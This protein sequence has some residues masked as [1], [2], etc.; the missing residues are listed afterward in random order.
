MDEHVD[1]WLTL[2]RSAV[3][4][5]LLEPIELVGTGWD[6][7]VLRACAQDGRRWIFRFPRRPELL[8]DIE[9]EQDLLALLV[10]RLPVDIPDW[11]IHRFVPTA[12]GRQFVVGY[13]E[14][15]GRPAAQE[16]DDSGEVTFALTLPPPS[17]YTDGLGAA[18]AALHAM[19]G[20]EFA[21][22]HGGPFAADL[23]ARTADL[24]E[25]VGT[26]PGDVPAILREYWRAWIQDDRL[27][28]FTTT[29]C[30]G[31]LHPEHTMIDENGALTGIIDWTDSEIGDPAVDF[32]GTRAVL[33]PEFGD[34]LLAAYRRAGGPI[35]TLAERIVRWQSIGPL[36]AARFGRKHGRV[37]LVERA[38]REIGDRADRLAAGRP[39][40]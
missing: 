3:P 5:L 28:D 37:E 21:K 6:S 20:R 8:P 35:G 24:L 14:L 29:L 19:D 12:S 11:Q 31:D 18:L 27:W 25:S 36:H 33:G 10:G 7:L 40:V 23:R 39:P 26:D 30:H 1:G 4:H 16:P 32:I 9:R 22:V 15:P 38:L 17:G 34:D 2:A 13:P